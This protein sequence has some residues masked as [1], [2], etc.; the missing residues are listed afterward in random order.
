MRC[1]EYSGPRVGIPGG[2]Q[3]G[4][5]G[6]LPSQHALLEESAQSQ[7]SGPVSP[8]GAGA[9]GTGCSDVRVG[10]T[11]PGYHPSGPVGAPGPSLYPGPS[12][13]RPWPIR[14]RFHDI[15]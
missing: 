7:R 15:S 6:V 12:E 11:A 2:Y 14:A 5:T 13:C 4:Y 10:G 9:V 1:G 8:A 3:G